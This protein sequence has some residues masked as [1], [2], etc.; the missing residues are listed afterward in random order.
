MEYLLSLALGVI[1]GVIAALL[2]A[3][4]VTKLIQRKRLSV[5]NAIALVA[6]IVTV[7]V[8]VGVRVTPLVVWFCLFG[9]VLG[10]LVARLAR[11]G[12][13]ALAALALGV[14]IA[15]TSG[16]AAG[17]FAKPEPTLTPSC[18]PVVITAT[19]APTSGT[20]KRWPS[21]D[22]KQSSTGEKCRSPC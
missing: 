10:V 21:D 13:H 12:K 17:W 15:F 5:G 7:A 14:V 9:A 11:G 3:Y 18:T 8:V 6:L 22:S 2:M 1:L 4:V 16:F 19:A 20:P